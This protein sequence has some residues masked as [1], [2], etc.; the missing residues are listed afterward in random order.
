MT[1]EEAISGLKEIRDW[2]GLPY[3]IEEPLGQ[4]GVAVIT[5]EMIDMAIKALE[6][7]PQLERIKSIINSDVYIQEDVL[8]YKA[9][10]EVIKDADS[11]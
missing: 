9:I 4:E 3:C 2:R 7:V 11:N 1:R 8:R 5:T 10:C 6:Q